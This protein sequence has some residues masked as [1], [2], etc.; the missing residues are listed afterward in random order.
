MQVDSEAY[1]FTRQPGKIRDRPEVE[2][3]YFGVWRVYSPTR[4]GPKINMKQETRSSTTHI[5]AKNEAFYHHPRV[6]NPRI[7]ERERPT[8]K[9]SLLTEVLDIVLSHA[10]PATSGKSSHQPH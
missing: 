6:S 2:G 1:H 3:D 7:L 10:K 4:L 5:D 9:L 8:L